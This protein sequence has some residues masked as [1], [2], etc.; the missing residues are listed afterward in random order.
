MRLL[1]KLSLFAGLI[2][3]FVA[4][5][6]QAETNFPVIGGPGNGSFEDRCPAGQYLTGIQGRAGAWTDQVQIVCERIVGEPDRVLGTFYIFP[7]RQTS[8]DLHYYG[9]VRGGI[10]GAAI[11]NVKCSVVAG[12]MVYMTAENRQVK[13]FDLTCLGL[14]GQPSFKVRFNAL[15]DPLSSNWNDRTDAPGYQQC[16]TGAAGIGIRGRYGK[17]VNALSLIC[18]TFSVPPP[19]YADLHPGA[20]VS[21]TPSPLRSNLPVKITGRQTGASYANSLF[22]GKWTVRSD[23]SGAFEIEMIQ[24][25]GGNLFGEIADGN[26]TDQGTLRGKLSDPLHAHL[27]LN[28]PG[29]NRSGTVDIA[30][31]SDGN[32]FTA[33]GTLPGNQP[34]AWRGTKNALAAAASA[35]PAPSVQPKTGTT[36]PY[37]G[38]WLVTVNDGTQFQL[39][40]AQKTSTVKSVFAGSIQTQNAPGGTV[41]GYPVSKTNKNLVH[42][43]FAMPAA[44]GELDL[45]L[46]PDGQ[47][48]FGAGHLADGTPI[49]WKGARVQAGT[50]P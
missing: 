32:S 11:T 23:V 22:V 9:P 10:Y 18:D 38:D 21:P 24:L 2:A 20:P 7:V 27:T 49:S 17:D 50:P 31:S 46:A 3:M 37:F 4:G 42:V 35:A 45:N 40:L 16:P 19:T 33:S 39:N 26:A 44:K 5:S 36:G 41:R 28:Q 43:T 29:L 1:G 14:N 34:L 25:T 6:A 15:R 30:L 48:F 47:S 13:F 12:L 8:R